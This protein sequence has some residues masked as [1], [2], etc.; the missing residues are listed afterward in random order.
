MKR[1]LAYT[2]ILV[3]FFVTGGTFGLAAAA[4]QAPADLPATVAAVESPGAVPQPTDPAGVPVTGEPEPVLSEIL[5]FYGLIGLTA[6]FLVLA[7][8]NMANKPTGR[9]RDPE[10]RSSHDANRH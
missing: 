10:G 7:L 3:G 4:P 2:F 1:K 5:V 8:L 9:Y 6:L